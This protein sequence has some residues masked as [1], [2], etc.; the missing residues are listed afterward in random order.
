MF[1]YKYKTQKLKL[2]KNTMKVWE[3]TKMLSNP[4]HSAPT[5]IIYRQE[6]IKRLFLQHILGRYMIQEHNCKLQKKN[7]QQL[8]WE[9]TPW[10]LRKHNND[11]DSGG[12]KKHS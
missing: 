7:K 8:K 11:W 6:M 2:Q 10:L 3:I 5:N 4:L 9:I 12:I 1:D